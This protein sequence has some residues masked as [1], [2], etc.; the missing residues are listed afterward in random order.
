MEGCPGPISDLWLR[1]P[2][3][4]LHSFPLGFRLLALTFRLPPW[5]LMEQR[6]VEGLG[7]Y[8]IAPP[9][10]P[11]TSPPGHP[12]LNVQAPPCKPRRCPCLWKG[13]GGGPLVV[14]QRAQP[15]EPAMR[16]SGSAVMLGRRLD[17]SNPVF[18]AAKWGYCLHPLHSA[19]AHMTFGSEHEAL[20]LLEFSD[21]SVSIGYDG[22]RP[23]TT[24]RWPTL[25]RAHCGAA[26]IQSE[27]LSLAKK[28][29]PP[30]RTKAPHIQSLGN[31]GRRQRPPEAAQGRVSQGKRAPTRAA[32]A[33]VHVA[34]LPEH[35]PR[36]SNCAHAESGPRLP[37]GPSASGGRSV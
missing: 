14:D 18:P 4:P 28:A 36:F 37:S 16:S 33:R 20:T 22:W 15:G 24:L 23:C 21:C 31:A 10:T 32:P 26:G 30:Q 29:S 13:V 3:L 5:P 25:C 11:D 27:S 9:L 6:P 35:E 1:N 8:P 2:S 7:M 12:S 34:V 19:P 17:P